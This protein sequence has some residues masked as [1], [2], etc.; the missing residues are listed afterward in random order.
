M[1]QQER[2]ERSKKEIFQAAMEE[3]GT[4]D[5]SAVT[6]EGICTR[7]GISKG[8]MYHYYTSKD[9]LFLLCVQDTFG[10]L[11]EYVQQ[12]MEQLEDK[13]SPAAVQHFF[14]S[15]EYFFQLHPR[16][17][18][19]FETAMLHPPRDLSSAI[20]ELRRPIREMN[21]A[22]LSGIVSKLQLRQGL[23]R[24]RVARYIES[25][26][27]IIRAVLEQYRAEGWVTDT[28]SMMDTIA[29]VLDMV[30]FGVARQVEVTE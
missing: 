3:F 2:Q 4:H 24:Q 7:H 29:E 14:I 6:M 17:K 5:Y 13:T 9:E 1:T 19:I 12:A 28:G 15:R 30:L 10:A 27:C 20:W 16:R 22:F 18:N 23:D 21:R 11:R 26:E 25:F 8:M